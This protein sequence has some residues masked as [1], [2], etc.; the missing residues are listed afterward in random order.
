MQQGAA[1]ASQHHQEDVMKTAITLITLALA[2][3]STT[4]CTSA[5]SHRADVQ[6][7]TADRV[8]VGTV[9][10]EIYV[11]MSGAEVASVLGSPNIVST[12]GE[13]NEVWIYDKF[14]TDAAYSKSNTGLLGLVVGTGGDVGAGGL[15]IKTY[16]SGAESRSQRT[17]TVVVKF[18]RER[19]VRDFA[20]HTARF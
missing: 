6:D 11:G 9:Q 15:G 4:G 7:D 8:T 18:D 20:Y 14:A 19:R 16:S 5:A 17:L 12:D 1:G 2:G 3:V 10:K 13:R